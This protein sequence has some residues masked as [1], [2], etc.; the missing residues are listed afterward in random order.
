MLAR[1]HAWIALAGVV[2][3]VVIATTQLLDGALGSSDAAGAVTIAPASSGLHA[4]QRAGAGVAEDQTLHTLE[5]L[6]QR[7]GDPPDADAGRM[8]I[9]TINVDAPISRRTV[10]RDGVLHDPIGPSDVAWYDFASLP[11]FGGT[12]GGGGNAVFAAHVD[13][14]GHSDYAGVDY[15]GP[16]IFFWLDRLHAGDVIEVTMR[17]KTLR[18]AVT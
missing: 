6:R 16:G 1:P 13:R 10:A 8:H 7:Y 11:G 18:Y 14:A 17:S 5:L 3:A 12:P 2:A 9:P 15:S 4:S